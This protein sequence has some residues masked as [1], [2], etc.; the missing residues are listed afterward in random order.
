MK[1]LIIDEK[2][3]GGRMDKLL[4]NYLSRAPQGFV[5]KMLRKKNIMLNDK[6]ASGH[7][8]VKSG[9]VIKLYLADETIE[10]FR[11]KQK[12]KKPNAGKVNTVNRVNLFRSFICFEDGNLLVINKPAGLLSQKAKPGDVSLNE[13]L[14]EYLDERKDAEDDFAFHPG[15]SNR[16]DRN[17]S[18][19]VLAGKNR[20]AVRILNEAIRN[21]S[22]TKKY[23]CIVEGIVEREIFADGYLIKNPVYTVKLQF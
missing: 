16:L 3:S 12:K 1:E 22:I 18:G 8:L 20:N 14:C 13:M 23:L 11:P 6:K 4:I 5:Y 17:T 7:E 19:I 9:D 15:I 10:K 2:N 21:R